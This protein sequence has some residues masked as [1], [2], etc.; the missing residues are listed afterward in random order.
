VRRGANATI[1]RERK[2]HGQVDLRHDQAI[3][4]GLVDE[5][6]M[7]ICPSSAAAASGSSLMV[8]E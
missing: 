6:Q 5:F 8:Y 4:S 2:S 1:E 3:R 7:I